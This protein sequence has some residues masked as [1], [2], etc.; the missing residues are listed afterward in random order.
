MELD[1]PSAVAEIDF[2]GNE[3][4]HH[5]CLVQ[6]CCI[7]HDN[8]EIAEIEVA[9]LVD[10]VVVPRTDELVADNPIPGVVSLLYRIPCIE[11][12]GHFEE[13]RSGN[14]VE[15]ETAAVDA[16]AA[17]SKDE[18]PVALAADDI[19]VEGDDA[20]ET[21]RNFLVP[22]PD[23]HQSLGRESYFDGTTPA[24]ALSEE[25]TAALVSKRFGALGGVQELLLL[26]KPGFAERTKSTNGRSSSISWSSC[27]NE[28][29]GDGCSI[30]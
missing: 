11:H 7:H 2:H 14:D 22:N 13:D 3:E 9:S 12:V 16:V 21:V 8:C 19:D 29:G 23:T 6:H 17:C 20:V 18:V 5:C 10:G 24:V 1:V 27:G 4:D 28:N 15:V 26:L 25:D 30:V